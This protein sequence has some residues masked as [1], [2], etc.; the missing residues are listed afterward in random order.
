MVISFISQQS[1]SIGIDF[2]IP[3]WL[4]EVPRGLNVLS[5]KGGSNISLAFRPICTNLGGASKLLCT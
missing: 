4:K 3:T 1:Q 5:R 2:H